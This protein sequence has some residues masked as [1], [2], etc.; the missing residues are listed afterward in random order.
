MT[1]RCWCC[2]RKTVSGFEFLVSSFSDF[3]FRLRFQDFR[4]GF[5]IQISDSDLRFRIIQD[6]R[7]RI[8][9][10]RFRFQ[11]CDYL[12]F[13]LHLRRDVE[14]SHSADT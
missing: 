10:L 12:R 13:G 9:D 7:F 5:Q 4:F 1:P 8:Q 3:K 2:A 11:I 14:C 6:L